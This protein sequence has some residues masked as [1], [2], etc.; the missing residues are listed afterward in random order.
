MGYQRHSRKVTFYQ[1]IMKF[2]NWLQSIPNKLTPPPFRLM[3]IGSAF[4]QSRALYVAASLDVATI[5]GKETRHVEDLAKAIDAAPDGLYRLLRFLAAGGIFTE[6]EGKNFTNNALSACLRRDVKDNVR[7]M[8]LMH[9][10]PTMSAPW[11]EQLESGVRKG[12]TPFKLSHGEDLFG[13]LNRNAQLDELFSDAMDSV[14]ALLGESFATDF[15]WGRFTRVI[16]VGGSK[17]SKA[18]TLL[19]HWPQLSAVVFDRPQVI[20]QL[21]NGALQS[22]H[23]SLRQR[24]CW[25]AGDM[26]V[27]VPAANSPTDIYLL[28]AVLHGVDD[29]DALRTLACISKAIGDTGAR[30]AI[31]ELV[32]PETGADL[33]SASFDMQMFVN[34]TGK[35]R[36]Q[37]QWCALFA[38]AG[39]KLEEQISLRSLGSLL[40][41]QRA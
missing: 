11:Y 22:L 23:D 10:H 4:W 34:S 2:G 41:L 9:N 38:Q 15:D 35:E 32:L 8:I 17:G 5:L 39:L 14:E 25:E 18:L 3:Q 37:S 1:G 7:S 30:I 33:A 40:L 6:S 36:T 29:D 21:E 28:C 19:R 31:M 27:E 20:S 24:I 26:L 13:F 12:I 16:D